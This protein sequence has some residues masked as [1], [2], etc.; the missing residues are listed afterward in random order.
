MPSIARTNGPM[1]IF[2]ASIKRINAIKTILKY[3]KLCD[4]DASHTTALL[5]SCSPKKSNIVKLRNDKQSN[6]LLIVPPVSYQI[7]DLINTF[8]NQ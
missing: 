8:I 3:A 2:A 7:R 4:V 6:T 1:N 5:G